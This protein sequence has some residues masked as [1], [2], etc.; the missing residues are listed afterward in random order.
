MQVGVRIGEPGSL[1]DFRAAQAKAIGEIKVSTFWYQTNR[2]WERLQ[3]D[4]QA[5]FPGDAIGA[6]QLTLVPF[7]DSGRRQLALL[8][9]N[10]SSIRVNG[11]PVPGLR[12][13]EHRDEIL[14]GRLRFYYS[15]ESTPDVVIFQLEPGAKRPECPVCR[16]KIEDGQHVVRCPG[17]GRFY[18]Q[19][20]QTAAGGTTHEKHCWTY[21]PVCAFDGHPT[22]LSGDPAWR[23]DSDEEHEHDES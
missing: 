18:H 13:L 7:H 14:V 20:E 17:C 4:G 5:G 10:D 8:G 15:A 22:S 21:R 23:P 19:Y 3:L 16:M 2:H 12:V 9:Q 1:H 11:Q 6:P